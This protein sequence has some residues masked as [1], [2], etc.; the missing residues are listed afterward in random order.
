MPK[1]A[2]SSLLSSGYVRRLV[3]ALAVQTANVDAAG[4][5]V[6]SRKT[7]KQVSSVLEAVLDGKL[8][9]ENGLS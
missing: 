7:L 6:V 5:C 4:M 8:R 2:C 3:R 1:R 9:E